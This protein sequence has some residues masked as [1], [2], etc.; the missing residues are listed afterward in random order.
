MRQEIYGRKQSART[1]VKQGRKEYKGS[2]D[3]ILPRL[4]PSPYLWERA[5]ER[6]YH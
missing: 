5:R 4:V 6:V 1:I 3:A 2:F